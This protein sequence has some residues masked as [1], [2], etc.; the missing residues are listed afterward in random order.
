MLTIT[1][2]AQAANINPNAMLDIDDPLYQAP[3]VAD[4]HALKEASGWTRG[5]IA[6]RLGARAKDVDK[7]LAA[8][9][10]SN[11]PIPWTAWLTWLQTAGMVTVK[12]KA[13]TCWEPAEPL[14][15]EQEGYIL[16]VQGDNVLWLSQNFNNEWE[17]AFSDKTVPIEA[18]TTDEAKE[19]AFQLYQSRKQTNKE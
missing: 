10:S 15:P 5:K 3:T 17:C 6:A 12:A 1:A 18:K 13:L 11:K 19:K 7:W 14:M 9:D 16:I 4:V 8:S 2:T